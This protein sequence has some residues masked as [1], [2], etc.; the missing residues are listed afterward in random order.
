MVGTRV[1]ELPINGP[2][3]VRSLFWLHA[4]PSLRN[5]VIVLSSLGDSPALLWQLLVLNKGK[6]EFAKVLAIVF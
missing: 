4:S 5:Q 1:V 6:A 3:L 2:L